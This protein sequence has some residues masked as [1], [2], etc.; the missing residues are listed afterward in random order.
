MGLPKSSDHIQI[1][2]KMPNP[3]QDPPESSKAPDEDLKD[4]MFFAP[5][6]SRERAKI[7]IMGV[8]TTIDHIQIKNKMP[9]PSQETPVSFKVPNWDLRGHGWSLHPSNQEREP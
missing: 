7:G 9:N 5:L 2:M 3:T 1:K 8:P 6:K 4:M